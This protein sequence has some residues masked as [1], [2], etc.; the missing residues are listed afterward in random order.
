MKII[1][2]FLIA[3]LMACKTNKNG[4]NNENIN[5][6]A[7][8]SSADN[9][10]GSKRKL[11]IVTTT[12][13]PVDGKCTVELLENSELIIKEDDIGKTFYALEQSIKS[14]V[15]RYKYIK[16]K[17]P[18]SSLSDGH[19]S[20]EIIF[21]FNHNEKELGFIDSNLQTTK[22]LF[23]KFCYCKGEAGYYKVEK[24]NLKIINE[25]NQ[26]DFKLD[27]VVDQVVHKIASISEKI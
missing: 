1:F 13:C 19:Y 27:F 14:S 7:Q 17:N 3:I 26:L 11:N 24:G 12:N 18:N 20:E 16:N 9:N 21:E 8:T 25:K 23:G 15:V 2:L 10:N 22:M 6:P 5:N 4:I